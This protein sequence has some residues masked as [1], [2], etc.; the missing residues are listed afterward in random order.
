MTSKH[1]HF[2][3]SGIVLLLLLAFG[4]GLN[5]P[6]M[7]LVLQDVPPLAFRSICLLAG[8]AGVLVIAQLVGETI[9]VPKADWKKLFILMACNILGWNFFSI[10]GVSM[11]PSG[12][13]VLIG[14][15]MPIW[16]IPLSVW[17][18]GEHLTI[19]RIG[20]LLLG[21]AGI[22]VMM[23]A[24]FS[25]MSHAIIGIACMLAAAISWGMGVVLMKRF[26]LKIPTISLTGWMMVIG[27]LPALLFSLMLE[28]S[29]FRPIGFIPALGILYN[30]FVTFMFCYWAWNRIV[31]TTPVVIS[32]LSAL[33][34]PVIGIVSGILLLG[35]QPGWQEM[36][37]GGLVLG[38]IAL[39]LS[40][41]GRKPVEG[42]QV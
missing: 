41:P 35:E 37:A 24:D 18:L 5:W 15:T 33:I 40:E 29:Q 38:A 25:R 2:S 17:L 22:V 8:G 11:M 23:S 20:G 26:A 31:L 16:S 4:W 32:S 7:K 1:S 30:V 3:R 6:I 36:V 28:R 39:V 27:G 10:Y 12:R 9:D 19:R 21:I 42:P 34:V 13:A 14:Y